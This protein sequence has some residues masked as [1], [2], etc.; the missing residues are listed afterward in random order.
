MKD[1]EMRTIIVVEADGTLHKLGSDAMELRDW[2]WLVGGYIETVPGA[3]GVTLILDENGKLKN[4]PLNRV[5]T[6]LYLDF[7]ALVGT[8]VVAD[9]CTDENGERDICGLTDDKLAE[10]YGFLC[11][12]K[13]IIDKIARGETP[14]IAPTL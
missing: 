5:A 10:V 3:K 13:A 2:Q 4:K 9:V 11:E 12:E 7:D 1:N 6:S 8:V 14:V